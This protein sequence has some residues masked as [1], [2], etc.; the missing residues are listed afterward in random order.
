MDAKAVKT[1][2]ESLQEGYLLSRIP[3]HDN[4]QQ[5]PK[6]LAANSVTLLGVVVMGTGTAGPAYSLAASLGI[7]AL[8]AGVQA[9]AVLII[10]FIPMLMSAA[11]FYSFAR[12]DPDCGQAFWWT[13]RA[14]GP[15]F[16]LV[17]GFWGLAMVVVIGPNVASVATAYGYLFLGLDG[18]ATSNFWLTLGSSMLMAFV[19]ALIA[20]GIK[21]SVRM[22]YALMALQMAGLVTFASATLLTALLVNLVGYLPLSA[23]WLIPVN[24]NLSMLVD[25]LLIGV[26]FY[27]GWDVAASLSEES[28][29][30]LRKPAIGTIL[31]AVLL[32]IIFVLCATG[33]QS[34][35]GPDFL[36]R[37]VEDALA[38]VT[39]H[40]LGRPWDKVVLLTV[41]ASTTAA[42]F[43]MMV[44]VTR[45]SLSMAYAGALPAVFGRVN[46]RY[47]TPL[48]GTVILGGSVMGARVVFACLNKN[49]VADLVPSLALLSA[50]EYALVAFA[51]VIYFRRR[52]TESMG[53]FFLM[54]FCPVLAGLVLICVYIKSLIKYWDPA[55]SF[56]GGW[57][58][59]GAIFW[60][61]AGATL[62]GVLLLPVMRY[63]KPEFFTHKGS[64][65]PAGIDRVQ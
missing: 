61:A 10:S 21:P 18:A 32:M 46:P 2:G 58:G 35:Q 20:L 42:A 22:Q 65:V 25:G 64:C 9:P 28:R 63:C 30:P 14:L 24:M 16:G 8:V 48:A 57:L 13:T 39:A 27:T 12:V 54:G 62:L 37:N 41:F 51:C 38:A 33:A 52:L 23:R 47:R 31:S 26:F 40:V 53:N 45:W 5:A 4:R 29:D 15:G 17:Q 44:Y 55:N 43:S 56:A 11:A 36:A 7:L 34:V 3:Q 6:G 60:L 49:L 1:A 50:L 59:I 19:T